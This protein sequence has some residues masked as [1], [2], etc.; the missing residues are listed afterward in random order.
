MLPIANFPN[1]SITSDGKVFSHNQNKYLIPCLFKK[2]DGYLGISL[3]HKGKTFQRSIHRLVALAYIPNPENK[4]QV[5]HINGIKSD[6]RVENLEW[7]TSHENSK[8]AFA[9]GLSKISNK[10]REIN[11]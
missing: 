11:R 3:C 2:P 9:L 5:N 4:S 8:H 6:N 7:V 1:Y 10:T